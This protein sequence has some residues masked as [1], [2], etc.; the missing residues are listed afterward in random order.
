MKGIDEMVMVKKICRILFMM[1]TVLLLNNIPAWGNVEINDSVSFMAIM[2]EVIY[3]NAPSNITV[4][5]I[6]DNA[7]TPAVTPVSIW[8]MESLDTSIL[9]Y[10]GTTDS[11][12][13]LTADINI[14][15]V[16]PGIYTIEIEAGGG[17]QILSAS[18]QVENMPLLLIETD[19]PIY[20]P[21]QIILD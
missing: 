7:N 12:G 15:P 9:I 10:E 3:Q 21:R 4:T 1:L 5:A 2:P 13:H 20:K 14:P 11:R 18:I 17:N 8:F 6:S 16:S 19:K